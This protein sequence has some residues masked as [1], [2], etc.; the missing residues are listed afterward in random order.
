MTF[1]IFAGDY[2]TALTEFNA[3][4]EFFVAPVTFSNVVRYD[5]P[6]GIILPDPRILCCFSEQTRCIEIDGKRLTMVSGKVLTYGT[7]KR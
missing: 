1:G 3:Y 5:P 7:I 6:P 4:L 2:G